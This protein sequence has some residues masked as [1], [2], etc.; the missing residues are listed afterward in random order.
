MC[1]GVGAA[2][3]SGKGQHMRAHHQLQPP[4]TTSSP[5]ENTA[6][7]PP[8]PPP[9]KKKPHLGQRV[10]DGQFDLVV[11][12]L[13][14]VDGYGVVGHVGRLVGAVVELE[15]W[16]GRGGGQQEHVV[17]SQRMMT[18]VCGGQEWRQACQPR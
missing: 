13:A 14:L 9:K 18:G 17:V 6:Q 10:A 3:T 11:C 12:A 15:L 1:K 16:W 2:A 5:L 7:Q 8:P 4:P